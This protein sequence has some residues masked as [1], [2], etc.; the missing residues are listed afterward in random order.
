MPL[1]SP[2]LVYQHFWDRSLL[3]F[4]S[5]PSTSVQMTVQFGP[6]PSILEASSTFAG[7]FILGTVQ[8]HP[9]GPS[10]FNQTRPLIIIASPKK[11]W[12]REQP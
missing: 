6:E 3:H 2:L 11:H 4:D 12:L 9:Y 10:T 1:N 8:F 5:R 7:L